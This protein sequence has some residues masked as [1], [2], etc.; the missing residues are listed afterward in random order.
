[1]KFKNS[2][3]II[4]FIVLLATVSN[5]RA[6]SPLKAT[7]TLDKVTYRIADERMWLV[8]ESEKANTELKTGQIFNRQ[9]FEKERQR[10]AGL[11]KQKVDPA[12]DKNQIR[13]L[14]DTTQ[15][16]NSFSVEILIAKNL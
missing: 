10:I 15:A 5:A 8:L 3:L 6:Q 14:V 13:F 4:A 9:T 2:F 16:R 11:I 7:Y 1:M 12:F